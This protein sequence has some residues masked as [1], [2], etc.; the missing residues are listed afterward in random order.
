[1]EVSQA[2]SVVA[3]SALKDVLS[4]D[5]QS[6]L[7]LPLVRKIHESR[8]H[9]LQ[10][11]RKPD[12]HGR[13]L[14]RSFD[15]AVEDQAAILDIPGADE[16]DL[17]R[18]DDQ[19][20]LPGN[21][22][23]GFRVEDQQIVRPECGDMVLFGLQTLYARQALDLRNAAAGQCDAEMVRVLGERKIAV[24]GNALSCACAG[25]VHQHV[26]QVVPVVDFDSPYKREGIEKRPVVGN[27]LRHQ[28]I[29]AVELIDG[30]NGRFGATIH[31]EPDLVV[32]LVGL[33]SPG[34]YCRPGGDVDYVRR[35]H[36]EE[37]S[38]PNRQF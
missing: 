17:R 34:A 6:G 18:Y 21:I 29:V 25:V 37:L 28:L 3:F 5:I 12:T 4:R 11:P 8:S 30:L 7:R 26:L 38:P 19:V 31:C 13:R 32:L 9:A 20:V 10:G 33:R 2:S 1:M 36:Q 15:V 16:I 23:V 27:K 14:R 24:N 22:V 35:G